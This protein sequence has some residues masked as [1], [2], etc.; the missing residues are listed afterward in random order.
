MDAGV[1]TRIFRNEH[2]GRIEDLLGGKSFLDVD[3]YAEDPAA[4][5]SSKQND[6]QNF[7]RLVSEDQRYK[8]DYAV[9]GFHSSLFGKVEFSRLKWELF[10]AIQAS[11]T[12]YR[13]DGNYHGCGLE[14]CTHGCAH[15]GYKH[16][17]G[18]DNK[19]HETKKNHRED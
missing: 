2:F 4:T 17:V 1:N 9:L 3:I 13:R 19:G 8:Y 15:S 6:L 18:P 7:N 16:M 10:G 14:K 5:G 11:G 12:A